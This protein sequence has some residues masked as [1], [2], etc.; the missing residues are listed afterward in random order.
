MYNVLVDTN[1]IRRL[2]EFEFDELNVETTVF[3]IKNITKILIKNSIYIND[4]AL[5]ELIDF[6]SK[7]KKGSN[8]KIQLL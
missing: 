1:I 6:M 4:Q 3:K 8:K 7:D 5:F 2:L